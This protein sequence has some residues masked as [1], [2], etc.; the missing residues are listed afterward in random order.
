MSASAK[1]WQ[2]RIEI[3]EE[4]GWE[5]EYQTNFIYGETI[6]ILRAAA[7][8]FLLAKKPDRFRNGGDHIIGRTTYFYFNGKGLD[9][10]F[11]MENFERGWWYQEESMTTD[12]VNKASFK[13]KRLLGFEE[14]VEHLVTST[15]IPEKG[16][17][18]RSKA[19]VG[20]NFRL[21]LLEKI[22]R[23]GEAHPINDLIQRGWHIIGLEYKGELSMTGELINR[24]AVF[25]MGH[26]EVQV[27]NITLNTSYFMDE[28]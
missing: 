24:Q 27:A 15:L 25:V 28:R 8:R 4:I 26:P 16:P 7:R 3:G 18:Y 6:E 2:A 21:P 14:A 11:Q 22:L 9:L 17:D 19:M 1:R 13:P 5:A 10:E 20:D 23:E 12:Q